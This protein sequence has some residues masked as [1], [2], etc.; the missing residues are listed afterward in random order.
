MLISVLCLT[1][2]LQPAPNATAASPDFVTVLQRNLKAWDKDRNNML[3]P[4]E[5]D[6]ALADPKLTGDDAAAVGTIK[7]VSRDNRYRVRRVDVATIQDDLRIVRNRKPTDVFNEDWFTPDWKEAFEVARK[8]IKARG[9][10]FQP[11]DLASLRV[12]PYGSDVFIAVLGATVNWDAPLAQSTVYSLPDGKMQLMLP[13]WKKP[14]GPITE[15]QAA[16]VS[17]TGNAW[18]CA[19]QCGVDLLNQER[20][21]QA[22]YDGR[23]LNFEESF[24]KVQS[25]F[26]ILLG[27]Q[28]TITTFR[29][30]TGVRKKDGWE[31]R[32][33]GSPDGLASQISQ[34]FGQARGTK[35]MAVALTH[36]S[37]IVA[38][39][40]RGPASQGPLPKGIAAYSYFVIVSMDAKAKTITLW[41]PRGGN[42]TP[43]GT[44]SVVNGYPTTNG[45]WTMPLNDFVLVFSGFVVENQ[46]KATLPGQS[47][48][49]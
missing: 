15:A 10:P 9:E 32:P 46:N 27:K 11:P 48:G 40:T 16:S 4:L 23:V 8:R 20:F 34:V 43:Q 31:Y 42:F 19:V 14:F 41:S 24:A 2:A 3:S 25:W 29:S 44:P 45:K 18:A 49:R 37:A 7:C 1:L 38:P 36:G 30:A 17:T 13:L 33:L 21:P 28:G 22:T 5:I 12:D 6:A 35:P 26:A 47:K 39:S